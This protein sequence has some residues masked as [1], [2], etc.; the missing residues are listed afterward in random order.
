MWADPSHSWPAGQVHEVPCSGLDRVSENKVKSYG[1][2]HL[3]PLHTNAR[4]CVYARLYRDR[5]TETLTEIETH[6]EKQ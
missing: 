4:A 2:R 1:G 6:T 3:V 5:E